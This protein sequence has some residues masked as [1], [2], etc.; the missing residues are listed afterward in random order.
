MDLIPEHELPWINRLRARLQEPLPGPPAQ[1]K[2]ASL[3]RLEELATLRYAPPDDARV[4]CVLNLIHWRDG[5]WRTVLIQRATN[6]RDRHSAQVSFPGGRY[7]DADGSLAN[8]ALREAEEEIGVPA[9]S[10]QLLGQ[11]TDLYIPVSNF[12]VHPFVG[13]LAGAAPAEFRAQPGEVDAVLTPSLALFAD[14]ANHDKV[15][16]AIGPDVVLKAVPYYAI[17]GHRVWGATAMIM[18][19]F[20]ELLNG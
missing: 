8:A 11:L 14:P 12:I 17:E 3:R 16:I 20:L 4:A 6:P 2:M 5:A 18:S 7:E 1:Y 9:A 13:L 15:D 19:E 10:I